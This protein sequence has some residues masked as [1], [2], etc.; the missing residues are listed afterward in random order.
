MKGLGKAAASVA[1]IMLGGAGGA[2]AA[3]LGPYPVK[4]PVAGPATCTSLVDF[5]TTACQLSAYGV[6]FYGTVDAGYSYQT[7]GAPMG[8]TIGDSYSLGK[9]NHGAQWVLGP[10]ALSTSNVGFQIKEPLWHDW[11]FVGQVETGFNPYSGRL[12]DAP[13]SLRTA[14]GVPLAQQTS[15]TDANFNGQFYNDLGFAGFSHPIWGTLTY[16]RQNS[17]GAD[18][19]LSYD[20][21][22]SAAAFSPLGLIGTY[23]GGGDTENRRD[24]SA[25][26]YRVNFANYH[27]G[28]YAAVGGYDMGNASTQAY[29]GNLGGDWKVGPGR[30]SAD[31]TA[32]WR[33]N[34]L[35]EGPGGILGPVDINGVPVNPFTQG[36][37][38]TISTSISNNTQVMVSGKYELDRLKLYAGWDFMSFSSPDNGASL[39]AST[40]CISDISGLAL[41]AGCGNGTAFNSSIYNGRILQMAWFGG[42]YALTDSLDLSAGY[43]HVWQNDFSNGGIEKYSIATSATTS[44]LISTDKT[45]T[46]A[47]HP[48]I[49]IQCAGTQDSASLLLDWKFAPK[50]DTYIGTWYTKYSGGFLSGYLADSNWTTTAGIRFRW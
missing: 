34:A 38:E 7:N 44:K 49:S 17:L 39:T 9:M 5:F 3:D 33:Q 1:V 18:Q 36:S 41:G 13:A 20:P 24:T 29:Y 50:W 32:G 10:N 22:M 47:Q 4:A 23:A 40:T 43:Y 48:T 27:F 42:R 11:S 16:G 26:K 31:V 19:V 25:I 46:C 21:Q 45:A 14:I 15:L 6:R 35:G 2:Y 8:K 37:G 28:A 30:L 12:L